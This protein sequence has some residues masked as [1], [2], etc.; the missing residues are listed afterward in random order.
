M[1]VERLFSITLLP[2]HPEGKSCS[3]VGRLL[4][5]N[6]SYKIWRIDLQDDH[7]SCQPVG[8]G[9]TLKSSIWP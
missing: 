6:Q 5:L 2:I 7:E 3:D 9:M 8:L 1:S 4:I